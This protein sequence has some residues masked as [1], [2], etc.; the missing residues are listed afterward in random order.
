MCGFAGKV[1]LRIDAS[2]EAPLAPLQA[3][4][5]CLDARGPDARWVG[6]HGGSALAAT[7]L[8]IV[9]RTPASDPPLRD[10][11]GNVVLLYNGE[12]Y[13]A[14]RLRTELNV[15][16]RRLRT[17]GDGE[18]VLAAYLELGDDFLRHVDGMFALA[19]V[20][21]RSER[22]RGGPRVL[23]ARD[24]F[25][26][27]PLLW[28]R[29]AEGIAFASTMAALLPLLDRVD[30]DDDVLAAIV[31]H[32]FPLRDTT[33]VRGVRRVGAGERI[34]L[35][36]GSEA[37]A[38]WTAG[39][40][41]DAAT[42]TGP[43]RALAGELY[44]AIRRAVRRRARSE[45]GVGLFLSG[46]IDSGAIARALHDEGIGAVAFTAGFRGERDERP[47]ARAT[48][49]ACG[50]PLRELELGPESLDEWLPLTRAIGE[51]LADAS[52]LNVLALARAARREVGVVL[53]GEGGDELLGGYRRE[54][55]YEAIRGV[56][57]PRSVATAISGLPGEAGRVGA[58]LGR[59]PG[60]TRYLEL[61]DRVAEA[62]ALLV[63]DARASGAGDDEGLEA[64][65]GAAD[66][67]LR[68]YLPN[69]LLFRLDA[70]TSSASLE[71]RAPFLDPD[72]AALARSLP[73]RARLGWTSGKRCLRAALD[74]ALPKE[75]VRGRKRG[76][77]APLGRW[78]REGAFAADVL[79][80]AGASAPPL[81][82][83]AV[84]S[85]LALHRRGTR[86]RSVVL[87]RAIAVEL[88]RRALPR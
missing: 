45:V 25:G 68:S 32:G 21:R 22:E 60:L 39:V 69:D 6:R 74:G 65:S 13:E 53:A 75:V 42:R 9:D 41:A 80:G 17:A 3:A 81:D 8:A 1:A 66:S 85:A 51:P 63:P 84:E 38:A 14:E 15:R 46:G 10:A 48:A 40:E 88:F 24:R 67:D 7:R 57:V 64:G 78:F 55:A 50:I 59:E 37:R 54:R 61:R 62:E 56:R 58:A 82:R 26:E 11:S 20:D 49:A 5:A 4:A 30:A 73:D 47:L 36:G 44:G 2:A 72:L 27:K 12:L 23:L 31:R 34:V 77:G 29:T 83:R 33:P 35:E 52:I 79:L 86:D 19:I 18:L 87:A 28:S 76:F 43:L 16:G 71:A 70:A